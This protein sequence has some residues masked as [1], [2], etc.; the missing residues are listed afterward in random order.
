MALFLAL[1]WYKNMATAQAKRKHS[2]AIFN[3]FVKDGVSPS[4]NTAASSRCAQSME[5]VWHFN[6]LS[7]WQKI[8]G[9]SLQL[10][11]QRGRRAGKARKRVLALLLKK[12]LRFFAI[13]TRRGGRLYGA[14]KTRARRAAN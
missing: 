5:T 11:Q 8:G 14:A 4:I 13:R 9:G 10:P 6:G 12:L 3:T 2:A 1:K 7:L